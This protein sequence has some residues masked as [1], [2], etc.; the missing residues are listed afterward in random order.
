MTRR[1]TPNIQIG[2]LCVRNLQQLNLRQNEP[3]G[4]LGVNC[5]W[6][7]IVTAVWRLLKRVQLREIDEYERVQLCWQCSCPHTDCPVRR[8]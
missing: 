8:T 6:S 5:G 4:A 2:A 3:S 1:R 7:R